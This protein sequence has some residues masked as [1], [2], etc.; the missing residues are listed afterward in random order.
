M[1]KKLLFIK[2]IL[3]ISLGAIPP[4]S[5]KLLEFPVEQV[6]LSSSFGVVKDDA[7]WLNLEAKC[8]LR[9]ATFRELIEQHHA[10]ELP[11]LLTVVVDKEDGQKMY[12]FFESNAFDFIGEDQCLNCSSIEYYELKPNSEP[13][14][15]PMK[16]DER[17][18]AFWF[19]L[20]KNCL[21]TGH[22]EELAFFAK[23]INVENLKLIEAI[24]AI[25][26]KNPKIYR[27]EEFKPNAEKSNSLYILGVVF[28]KVGLE[29]RKKSNEYS[30][31][32]LCTAVDCL[33]EA[34]RKDNRYAIDRFRLYSSDEEFI[35]VVNS[36][37]PYIAKHY[38]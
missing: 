35:R 9:Q 30:E 34:A 19:A 23:N 16:S 5:I 28:W 1:I 21:I 24:P 37:D 6:K 36:L 25:I 4:D 31:S 15:S 3:S 14:F 10:R 38:F 20:L 2:L 13:F 32:F 29:I 27:A 22:D 7:I 26:V 33:H 17:I 12:K 11:F 18:E 8:P